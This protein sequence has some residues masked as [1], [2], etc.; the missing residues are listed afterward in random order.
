LLKVI[1]LALLLAQTLFPAAP[2]GVARSDANARAAGNHKALAAAIGDRIFRTLW[3]A[4]VLSIYDDSVGGRDVVGLRISGKH[5]HHALTQSQLAGEIASLAGLAFGASRS[6]EE[7]DAWL[8]VPLSEGK[9]IAVVSDVNRP[10]W[11]TV[12]S[13]SVRR[14]E[15]G[16]SIVD[17]IKNG[18]GVFVDQDWKRTALK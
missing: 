12:L 7:V 3:P 17:R 10:S 14:G 4:Q 15:A 11:S 6:I 8:T 1:S 5:F 13:V 2:P 9:G 18:A 16:A